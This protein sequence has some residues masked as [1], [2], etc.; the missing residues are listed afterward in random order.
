MQFLFI[1]VAVLLQCA[2]CYVTL[3][4]FTTEVLLFCILERAGIYD[5]L[6]NYAAYTCI[7]LLSLV[8]VNTHMLN[9]ECKDGNRIE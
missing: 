4:L 7:V 2:K 9:I 1:L 5:Y 8:S 6:T 3:K